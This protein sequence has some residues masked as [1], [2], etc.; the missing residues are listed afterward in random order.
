M[1]VINLKRRWFRECEKKRPALFKNILPQSARMAGGC[2]AIVIRGP[3]RTTP[4]SNAGRRRWGMITASKLK[5]LKKDKT[6]LINTVAIAADKLSDKKRERGRKEATLA[7][8]VALQK[9]FHFGPGRL[10][11][12]V[13]RMQPTLNAFEQFPDSVDALERHWKNQ[14]VKV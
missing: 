11:R 6:R 4:A 3:A 10:N 13:A 7:M 14:G 2:R 12:V 1:N 9:E 8:L 5:K